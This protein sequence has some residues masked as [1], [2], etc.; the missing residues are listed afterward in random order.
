MP[1]LAAAST[2][3][4]GSF[5]L[6]LAEAAPPFAVTGDADD[7]G[8]AFTDAGSTAFEVPVFLA[9]EVTVVDFGGLDGGT[10]AWVFTGGALGGAVID[11][12]AATGADPPI[13]LALALEAATD[14]FLEADFL[15]DF[16]R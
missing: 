2:L 8:G 1:F 16:M 12:W 11:G 13:D 10:G 6:D 7:A 9:A 15:S 14:F 4:V 3:V 5:T